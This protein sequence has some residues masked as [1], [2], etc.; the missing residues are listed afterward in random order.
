MIIQTPVY[1]PFFDSIRD[2]ERRIV[3]NPLLK[4]NGRYEIDFDDL[5]RKLA[6]PR[7]KLLLFCSPHNPTGRVWSSEDLKQVYN[8]CRKYSVDVLSDEIHSD[9]VYTGRR[10]T[11]YASLGESVVKQSVTFMAASKTFNIAG[12]NLSFAI[13]PCQ[14]RRGLINA[15]L[16]RLHLR[17]N[18]LFG[19]LASEAAYRDGEIW[20]ESLL[21]YLEKNAETLVEFAQKRLPGIGVYK[22]EGTYLAW[23]DFRSC[24]SSAA[25]L[26]KFLVH[27]AQVG[28][29]SGEDFGVAG[30]GFARLNFATQRST[31]LEALTRIERALPK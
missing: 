8:L 6:E 9:L 11:V 25:E 13:V 31:L 29:N 3:E 22:P 28:F 7:N 24:F 4:I 21:P 5:E 30:A 2:N 27:Q 14:R 10:H 12:L 23:L 15:W 26:R 20:L 16:T 17:R 19:V 1:P 18:N